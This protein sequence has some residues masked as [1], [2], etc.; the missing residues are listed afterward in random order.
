MARFVPEQPPPHFQASTPVLFPLPRE[1][2]G[3]GTECRFC[4][5][6]PSW[7]G[8]GNRT[9]LLSAFPPWKG[10]EGIGLRFCPPFHP[11]KGV[12]GIGR[13]FCSPFPAGKGVRGIGRG[14]IVTQ[15]PFP[16]LGKGPG[17]RALFL[18]IF[19][20]HHTTR[21]SSPQKM[22]RDD[23]VRRHERRR[24]RPARVSANP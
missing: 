6:F 9:L 13:R 1:K 3:E 24:D 20:R 10:R 18:K 8:R 14:G 15:I 5:P 11:G 19:A 7:K 23:H 4:S 17:V 12:M 16:I 22:H 21:S 2:S